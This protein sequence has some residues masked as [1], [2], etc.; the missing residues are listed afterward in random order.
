MHFQSTILIIPGLGNSGPQHWQSIWEKEFNFIRIEQ[1]DWDTP[2]CEDWIENIN[3]EIKKH[4]ASNVILVGHSLACATI[5]YWA[6]KFNVKIKGALLVA[7]SDTEADS[8]PTGT[9]GFAP[10]PLVKLPFKSIVI[11]SSNDYY[12]TMDRAQHFT[13]SWGSEW[14]NIG[15]AGHINAASGFG[16]FNQGLNL[17]KR[18]DS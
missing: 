4:D 11:A 8:Y 18:L 10:V 7:P 3:Q 17:L 6:Q 14:V 5:A 1:K 12:V 2:V 15:D 16:E 13:D 9:T